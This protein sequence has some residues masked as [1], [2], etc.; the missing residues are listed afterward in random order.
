MLRIHQHQIARFETASE[1]EVED[2]LAMHLATYFP[3]RRQ[4]MGDAAVR[5]TIRLAFARAEAHGMTAWRDV[6]AYLNVMLVLGSRFD[7][8]PQ[9]PWARRILD[10]SSAKAPHERLQRLLADTIGYLDILS[11]RDDTR[12]AERALAWLRGGAPPQ[13]DV[14]LVLQAISPEKARLAGV[15]ALQRMQAQVATGAVAAGVTGAWGGILATVLGFT[16]G[17][18]F[19]DDPQ[20]SVITGERP[21]ADADALRMRAMDYLTRFIAAAARG[22]A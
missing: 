5:A 18:G 1:Q 2:D 8:D 15:P 13:T 20:L 10:R 22:E 3:A 14:V 4:L 11:G 9:I 6:C 16:F 7:D 19:F 21:V 17:A 12:L